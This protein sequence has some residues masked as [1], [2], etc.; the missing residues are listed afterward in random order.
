MPR[1]HRARGG[2]P[3]E[4][5]GQSAEREGALVDTAAKLS[6]APNASGWTPCCAHQS[7]KPVVTW[8]SRSSQAR[9]LVSNMGGECP[10]GRRPN[11]PHPAPYPGPDRSVG[12]AGADDGP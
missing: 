9:T 2:W 5:L 4:V 3:L 10:P 11:P 7:S 6:Q 1:E 12:A 8:R